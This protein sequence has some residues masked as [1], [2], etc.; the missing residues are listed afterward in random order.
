[1]PRSHQRGQQWHLV[2]AV[3]LWALASL[4]VFGFIVQRDLGRNER[5]F[6]AYGETLQ[7]QLRDKLRANEAVLYGFASFLGARHASEQAAASYAASVLERYPHIYQLEIV[8][9]VARQEVPRLIGRMQRAGHSDFGLR[10]F[11]PEGELRAL[12]SNERE[13]YYP[14]VFTAP[15]T[16]YSEKILG[17][18]ISA[19][20][21]VIEGL[22]LSERQGVA[23]SSETFRLLEG[24]L[25]YIIFRP[26]ISSKLDQLNAASPRYAL[27]VVRAVD[28]VPPRAALLPAVRHTLFLRGNFTAVS[29]EAELFDLAAKPADTL[30]ALLLPRLKFDREVEDFSQP[31][32]LTLERQLRLSDFDLGALTVSA[33]ASALSAALLFA[34]LRT[35][36]QLRQQIEFLALYDTLTGL[37]NRLLLLGHL[38]KTVALAQRQQSQVAV[39][40][41][42]L[43]EFKPVNDSHGHAAGDTLLQTVARRLQDSIRNCD[44]AARLGGDEFVVVLSDIRKDKDALNVADKILKTLAEP[45]LIGEKSVPVSASIGIAIFPTD[46]STP[47]ELLSAADQAMYAA[48]GGGKGSLGRCGNLDDSPPANSSPRL[49]GWTAGTPLC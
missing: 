14:V 23:V 36:T 24:D 32:H 28:L 34:F 37:P 7:T 38:K 12:P 33:V 11:S 19:R 47:E 16:E 46:G 4:A 20:K 26:V 17:L 30:S 44:I 13:F 40:F 6:S 3:V 43:D 42:D 27:L 8:A 49:A 9:R 25:G 5:E 39:L 41:V 29:N 45:A 48:K 18:D 1:M 21:T 35:Q 15:T 31:V 2:L 10:G 22:L